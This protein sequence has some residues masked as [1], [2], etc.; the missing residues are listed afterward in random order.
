MND[1]TNA[2]NSTYGAL[3]LKGGRRVTPDELRNTVKT[4]SNFRNHRTPAQP[5]KR[6][7]LTDVQVF[8]LFILSGASLFGLMLLVVYGLIAITGGT[9]R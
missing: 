7:E 4:M 8:I 5:S 9:G 3:D 1:A 6:R 2:T